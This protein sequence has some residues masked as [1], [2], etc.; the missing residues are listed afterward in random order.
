MRQVGRKSWILLAALFSFCWLV[1]AA[2]GSSGPPAG[3]AVNKDLTNT[4][5]YRRWWWSFSQRASPRGFVPERAKLQALEQIEEHK[6]VRE[7]A[8]RQLRKSDS[9]GVQGDKWV[10]IGPMPLL[11]A[12]PVSGRIGDVAVNPGN[13]NHWLIGAA[14]GGVWETR[15][16]GATWTPKTD[17]QASLAMGA[18][19]FAPSNTNIIYAGTGEGVGSADAYAGLGLLKSTN[20]GSS[21]QLLATSNFAK[22][23]FSDI[24]VNPTNSNIL[25]ATFQEGRFATGGGAVDCRARRRADRPQATQGGRWTAGKAG[26]S[27]DLWGAGHH[28]P[29]QLR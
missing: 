5:E 27:D 14:Q 8:T 28:G 10:S 9:R 3:V 25:L 2:S 29:R 15:N 26:A 22:A 6:K 20:G 11:G 18:I 21:W 17:D 7:G 19:A 12:L 24:K 23:S 4:L 16:A 1:W 13:S